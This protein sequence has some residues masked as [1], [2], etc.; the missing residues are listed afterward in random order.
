MLVSQIE[1][2]Q[3][4]M[5]NERE[6]QEAE[7]T[8]LEGKLAERSK[9]VARIAVKIEELKRKLTESKREAKQAV[10]VSMTACLHSIKR[11]ATLKN[12]GGR[13]LKRS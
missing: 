3:R 4:E 10:K 8:R 7:I 1:Q 12:R 9:K 11:T 5:W 2:L 13:P 6:R